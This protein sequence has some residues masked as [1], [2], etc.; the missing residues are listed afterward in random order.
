MKRGST[1]TPYFDVCLTRYRPQFWVYRL[2]M[3]RVESLDILYSL[4]SFGV[5]RIRRQRHKRLKKRR[6]IREIMV[7]G[8]FTVVWIKISNSKAA[9]AE[10][11]TCMMYNINLQYVIQNKE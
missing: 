4:Y 2:E 9:K 10:N 1:L 11:L 3:L 7:V 5:D 6:Q 8:Q